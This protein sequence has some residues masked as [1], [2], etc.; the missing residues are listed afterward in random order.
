MVPA[1]LTSPPPVRGCRKVKLQLASA[2]P[3]PTLAP[4]VLLFVPPET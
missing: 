2:L 3:P 1:R 4:A